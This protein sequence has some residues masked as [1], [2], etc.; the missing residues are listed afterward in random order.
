M[1][2]TIFAQNSLRVKVLNPPLKLKPGEYF[3]FNCG[4]RL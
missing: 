1:P 3:L 2:L 4:E